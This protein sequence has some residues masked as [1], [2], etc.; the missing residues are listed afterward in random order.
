MIF[1]EIITFCLNIFTSVFTSLLPSLPNLTIP[2][3]VVDTVCHYASML[4]VF[5]PF[6]T[7]IRI[8][9]FEIGFR[10]CILSARLISFLINKL[11]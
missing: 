6:G 4:G 11:T 8:I 2:S 7:I 1:D 9:T 5:F 3:G 10:T